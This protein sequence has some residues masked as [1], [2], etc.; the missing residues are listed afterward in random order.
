MGVRDTS[1]EAYGAL[2]NSDGLGHQQQKIFDYLAKTKRFKTLRQIEQDTG[3]QIN[4]VS[5]RV[6]WLKNN[7]YLFE[8]N[9]KKCP[10]SG[11]TVIPVGVIVAE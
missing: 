2:V 10:I 6:N 1:R 4:A 9:R 3:I 7:K 11:R 8:G 5:G